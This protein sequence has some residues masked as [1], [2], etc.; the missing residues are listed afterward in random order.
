MRHAVSYGLPLRGVHVHVTE[1]FQYPHLFRDA[2]ASSLVIERHD[3]VLLARDLLGHA[4]FKTTESHYLHAE[5]MNAGVKYL[6]V[7][8][9]ERRRPPLDTR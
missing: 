7:L 4:S 5:S 3:Q 9:S 1:I 2:A 8:E 6:N